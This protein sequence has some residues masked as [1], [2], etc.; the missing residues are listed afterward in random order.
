MKNIN[1]NELDKLVCDEVLKI[2]EPTGILNSQLDEMT[3]SQEKDSSE[4]NEK[5][6]ELQRLIKEHKEQIANLVK[7][8]SMSQDSAAMLQY[9]TKEIERLD[10]EITMYEKEMQEIADVGEQ[11]LKRNQLIDEIIK[12]ILD[13]RD[14]YKNMSFA[15]K[16]DFMHRI[17][18]RVE[19]DG[20]NAHIFLNR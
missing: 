6:A 10:K 15:E 12:S 11:N 19:W 18:N 16:Q 14:N 5:L 7:V 8:L 13:F 1:G 3:K 4:N 17:I 2:N 9:T 20:D